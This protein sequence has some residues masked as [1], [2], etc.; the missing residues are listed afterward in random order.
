MRRRIIALGLAVAGL[1]ATLGLS[2][3]PAQASPYVLEYVGYMWPDQC[4]W[5]GQQ[6][7]DDHEWV[8]YYCETVY[9]TDFIHPGSY[10]LWVRYS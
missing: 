1:A 5:Y 3:A 8:A 10:N 4:A 6:G 7:I 2:A 9:P